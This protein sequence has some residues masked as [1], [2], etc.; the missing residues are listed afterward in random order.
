MSS[1]GNPIDI[2]ILGAGIFAKEAHLPALEKLRDFA[3]V[4]AVYSRSKK[5]AQDLANT[6]Q[7]TLQTNAIGV[8][9][10]D[11]NEGLDNLL[12]RS[13]IKAVL[14]ILPI[15]TQPEI[16]LKSLAAGKHVLSEKPI[17]ASVEDGKSLIDE[18]EAKHKANNLVWRVAENFEAEPGIIAAGEAFRSGAIGKVIGFSHTVAI[19]L[20][21]SSKWYKTPWRTVP[22][23]QGGFLLDGGVHQ[24]AILRKILPSRIAYLTGF[25]T[26]NKDYLAPHDTIVTALKTADGA[27]GSFEL[28]FAAPSSSLSEKANRTIIIG[29]QGWAE[30]GNA[31]NDKGVG[32]IR[33]TFHR[34]V[35]DEARKEVPAIEEPRCGVESELQS[36]FEAIGGKDDGLG[37]PREALKD[38]AIIQ[39]ALTSNGALVEL[40]KM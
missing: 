24:A 26:L 39:A 4:R 2:A 29:E 19:N 12:A 22:D 18:Y 1:S 36:F 34:Q 10:D 15:K 11:S 32:V 13:D 27:T 37:E 9:S 38:V 17:A 25:A 6:A 28:T 21:Q 16:I 30:V 7:K 5:S 31:T 8:Y 14:V 23:Y 33:T 3:V 35:G 20:D 40:D